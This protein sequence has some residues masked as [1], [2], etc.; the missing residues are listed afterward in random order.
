LHVSTLWFIIPQFVQ[1]LSI[2]LILLNVFIDVTYLVLYGTK[3]ALLVSIV[4]MISSHNIVAPLYYFRIDFFI[5]AIAILRHNCKLTLNT[6]V[7]KLSMVG[8]Y[9]PWVSFWICPYQTSTL[10]VSSCF[11][12]FNSM[13][14]F[15]SFWI[16]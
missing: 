2:F 16:S 3:S 5:L 13:Y 9:K 8:M 14:I 7:R 1:C 10:Y 4:V 11:I 6:I 12:F 15:S